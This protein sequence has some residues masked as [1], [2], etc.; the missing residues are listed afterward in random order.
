MRAAQLV[1]K[2]RAGQPNLFITLTCNPARHAS[3]LAA[4]KHMK[5]QLARFVSR[6]RETKGNEN[7]EY[8]A[9]A[10]AHKSGWPHFHMVARGS[11]I[12]QAWLK[13]IWCELTGAYQVKIRRVDDPKK[14]A[15]Y[16]AKYMAKAPHQF[17]NL[18]RYWC[19]Q[20]WDRPTEPFA[21]KRHVFMNRWRREQGDWTDVIRRYAALYYK[22]VYSEHSYKEFVTPRSPLWAMAG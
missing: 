3:P 11:F 5:K 6:I 8:L 21:S 16:I 9:V 14:A 2:A 17:G 12:D 22:L 4:A 1:A 7:F 18:K 20:K 19:S 13:R 10:E 15:R